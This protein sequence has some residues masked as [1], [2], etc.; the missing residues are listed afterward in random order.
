[1]AWSLQA[2]KSAKRNKRAA[3]FATSVVETAITELASPVT[4]ENVE[5]INSWRQNIVF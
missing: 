1:M 4:S 2:E 5:I 3:S